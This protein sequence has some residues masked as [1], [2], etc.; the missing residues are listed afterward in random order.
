[1]AD[2][3]PAAPPSS[4]APSPA[5][6]APAVRPGALTGTTYDAPARSPTD[7]E[8]DR[9]PVSEQGRYARV[10]D[11]AN[12][13]RWTLRSDDPGA[14]KPAAAPGEPAPP[15]PAPAASVVD[16][17]LRVGEYELSSDDIAALMATKAQADL[18]ATQVPADGSGYK[19]DLPAD[20][21]LPP[22]IEFKIDTA[23]PSYRDL[24]AFAHARGWDQEAFS[25]AIGIFASREA[26][27]AA[28]FAEAQRAEVQKLGANGTSRVTAVETWL[29]SELGDDL[30]NGMRSMMVT[31]KIVRGFEKLAGQ[32]VTQGAAPFSQAHR[33]PEPSPGPGRV[34]EEEYSRM[35]SAEKWEYARSFPQSQFY[36]D[37]KNGGSDR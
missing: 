19:P 15:A 31:E 2:P 1:M 21:Q 25:T 7:S 20:L 11:E 3:A 37:R 14:P 17:K 36:P 12:N 10:R 18:R 9:L 22:G 32:R 5:A 13:P 23:D 16:G 26:R 28:A 8:F 34:S 35:T 27:Q 24:A 6:P 4:P 33:T 29:R 30:A